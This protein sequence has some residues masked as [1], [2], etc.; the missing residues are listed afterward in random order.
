MESMTTTM[1]MPASM[2]D[3][4]KMPQGHWSCHDDDDDYYW[5]MTMANEI[6][7]R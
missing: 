1:T 3:C 5:M 7:F 6:D 4:K 2:W